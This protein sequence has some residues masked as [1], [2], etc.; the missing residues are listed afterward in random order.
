MPENYSVPLTQL[1]HV[2]NLEVTYAATDYEKIRL[3]VADIARP[4]LQLSGYF[5]HFEPVRLQV[6]GNVE[7][8]YLDKLSSAE[9]R[10]VFDR[11][12][13]YK[14]PALLVSRGM[15]HSAECIE[16]AKKHNVT[17]LRCHQSTSNIV[18]SIITYLNSE[19]A[20]GSPGTACSWRSTVRACCS[21]A[22]AA[23]ARAKPPLSC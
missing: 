17:L 10:I 19:L 2:F 4:G 13:R 23:S 20:P 8:S 7:M 5:D 9:R 21:S 22:K 14:F 12:F 18:S 11:L 16:M 15:E 3:T 1:V 6:V